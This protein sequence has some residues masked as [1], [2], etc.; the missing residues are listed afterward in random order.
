ML[1]Q[2]V[3]EGVEVALEDPSRSADPDRT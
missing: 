1:E 3:D 2:P